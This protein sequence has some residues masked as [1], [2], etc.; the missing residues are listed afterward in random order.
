MKAI[1]LAA[2]YATRLY[3]LTKDKAKPLLPV[4]GKP[5]IGYIAD[6]I[7]T[8]GEIDEIFVV[9]NHKF[10]KQFEEWAA[11]Y[12]PNI[13][14]KITVLDDGTL[15]EDI[16][17]GAIGDINFTIEQANI[18]DDLC[19]IAGD[20]LFTYKL[21]DFVAYH[22]NVQ[23]DC[24]IAKRIVDREMLKAFAVAEIDADSRLVSLVEKPEEPQSDIG[25]FASYLYTKDTV[26]LIREYLNEG[27][28]PDAPGYFVE[29]LY[30]RKPV[31]V[32]IMN[33]ECYDIGTLKAYEEANNSFSL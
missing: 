30:R 4:K 18:D 23:A 33:G 26:K 17:L 16:R 13:S 14:K 9:T 12:A 32:H 25:V 22:K 5:I 20:N 7:D 29:W 3:P 11:E 24:V 8:I 21:S 31:Y 1:I 2:G 6:Q 27:N 15:N 28:K 10:H 19:I